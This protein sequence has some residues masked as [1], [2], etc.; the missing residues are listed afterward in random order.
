MLNTTCKKL[1]SSRSIFLPFRICYTQEISR[2][3]QVYFNTVSNL[4]VGTIVVFSY[5]ISWYYKTGQLFVF[6]GFAYFSK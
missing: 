2:G 6:Y 3:Q 5:L 1:K 4:K